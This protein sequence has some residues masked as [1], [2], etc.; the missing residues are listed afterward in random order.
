MKYYLLNRSLKRKDVG[1]AF[2]QT[3]E[4]WDLDFVKG[5]P[6]IKQLES[7]PNYHGK[8]R[9]DEFPTFEPRI[10]FELSEKG[11]VTDLVDIPNI[12]C[13]GMLVSPKFRELLERF[14]LIEQRFYPGKLK[15]GD[16]FLEYFWFHPCSWEA[17]LLF[18][19]QETDFIDSIGRFAKIG[20][21]ADRASYYA[22]HGAA[23]KLKKVILSETGARLDLF[24]IPKFQYLTDFFISEALMKAIK[25]EKITGVEIKEQEIIQ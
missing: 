23:L 24:Y 12:N 6:Y 14:T 2:G 5:I 11:K 9:N 25:K 19:F 15:V 17:D 21:L 4:L 7:L 13:N 1:V 3:T 20:S 22:K 10:K 8:L 18:N 16:F